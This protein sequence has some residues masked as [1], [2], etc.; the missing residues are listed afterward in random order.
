MYST[1][2]LEIIFWLVTISIS[3]IVIFMIFTAS[4]QEGK[5]YILQKTYQWKKYKIKNE[6]KRTEKNIEKKN[7]KNAP[8]H[9]KTLTQ[10]EYILHFDSFIF[11]LENIKWPVNPEEYTSEGEVEKVVSRDE[12]ED[13]QD[14]LEEA[15]EEENYLYKLYVEYLK[16]HNYD[17]NESELSYV[18]DLYQSK[19]N[20]RNDIRTDN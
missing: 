13:Y 20:K 11:L 15:I 17:I 14:E 4:F 8:I 19:F 16:S 12:I 5:E 6:F 1:D 2:V 18:V 3:F 9:L 7:I 10:P